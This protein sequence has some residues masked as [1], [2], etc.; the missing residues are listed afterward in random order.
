MIATLWLAA[1]LTMTSVFPADHAHADAARR[2]ETRRSIG[3]AILAG[4]LAFAVVDDRVR[5]TAR[6]A[7]WSGPWGGVVHAE[8]TWAL[9]VDDAL[10]LVAGQLDEFPIDAA[11]FVVEFADGDTLRGTLAGRIRPRDDGT[12]A[13][14]AAFIATGGTGGFAKVASGR[15]SLHAVTDPSTLEMRTALHAKLDVGR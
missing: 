11:S 4:D 1:L 9:T 13:L 15:G 14:H 2:N 10:N 3:V 8:A 6:G 5:L 12:F 7:G